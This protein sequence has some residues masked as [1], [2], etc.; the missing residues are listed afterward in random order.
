MVREPTPVHEGKP[1]R[2]AIEDCS[3]RLQVGRRLRGKWLAAAVLLRNAPASTIFGPS[4][5]VLAPAWVVVEDRRTGRVLG[6]VS[7]GR[8]G[9]VGEHLLEIM[10]DDAESMTM[11]E[12][13]D[14]WNLR[15]AP[16]HRA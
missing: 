12:F 8:K 14:S 13:R 2:S 4:Y 16:V 5:D 9:G 3:V 11:S 7:A 1:R 6:R 15:P 10:Q